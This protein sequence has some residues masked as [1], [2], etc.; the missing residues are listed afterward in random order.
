MSVSG[1]AAKVPATNQ[2]IDHIA[3]FCQPFRI[4][5][6]QEGFRDR[7]SYV[8]AVLPTAIPRASVID[9]ALL[10]AWWTNNLK[11]GAESQ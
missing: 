5:V 7:E 1:P 3:I 6:G 4:R 11:N 2:T 10:C 8:I 9:R